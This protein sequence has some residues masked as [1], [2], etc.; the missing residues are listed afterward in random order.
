[1]KKSIILLLVALWG[2]NIY[3]QN[4]AFDYELKEGVSVFNDYQL[5]NLVQFT[6]DGTLVFKGTAD[7]TQL[8]KAGEIY[9]YLQSHE[10]LGNG[11]VGRIISVNK[12]TDYFIETEEVPLSSVFTTFN[13]NSNIDLSKVKELYDEQGNKIDFT[14]APLMVDTTLCEISPNETINNVLQSRRASISYSDIL[15]LKLKKEFEFKK[16]KI[17][18]DCYFSIGGTVNINAD[19]QELE[20]DMS[21]LISLTGKLE[22]SVEGLTFEDT[23][24][25]ICSIPIRNSVL[26][27]IIA[28]AIN[29]YGYFTAGGEVKMST[30][31]SAIAKSNV[32]I[33]IK[34]EI[35][36]VEVTRGITPLTN[37]F[38]IQNI[39]GSPEFGF[40]IRQFFGLKSLGR[41]VFDFK[42]TYA[43]LWAGVKGDVNIDLSNTEM[44]EQLKDAEVNYLFHAEVTTKI[45]SLLWKIIEFEREWKAEM[46]LNIMKLHLVPEFSLFT[47]NKI[48]N[49]LSRCLMTRVSHSTFLPVEIG[50]MLNDSEGALVEQASNLVPYK[51][52]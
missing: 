12:N 50:I 35:C 25:F 14:V 24:F 36:N 11:F 13:F 43:D 46:N 19:M 33:D 37:V 49:E 17:S 16:G 23:K 10:I 8:P 22:C 4:D 29:V 2:I 30:G 7:V 5:E 42:S 27:A 51:Y 45:E 40:G 31:I 38:N 6:E 20:I 18:A 44:Y 47:S 28:P 21:P 52:D 15:T 32:K 9:T 1:M 41:E 3:A 48:E 34:D 39:E 26:S